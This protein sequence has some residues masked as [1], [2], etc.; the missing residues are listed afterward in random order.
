MVHDEDLTS[1]QACGGLLGGPLLTARRRVIGELPARLEVLDADVWVVHLYALRAG[2]A[3]KDA[4][5]TGTH[6][7]HIQPDP[8]PPVTPVTP[9]TEAPFPA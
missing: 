1:L 9:V 3:A 4:T 7:S 2:R 8:C 6:S 5:H